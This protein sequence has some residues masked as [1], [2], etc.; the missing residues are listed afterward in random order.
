MAQIITCLL[1]DISF[2][3]STNLHKTCNN[4]MQKINFSREAFRGAKRKKSSTQFLN[5]WIELQ[6]ICDF[7]SYN[8]KKE[9]DM[10]LNWI[11]HKSTRRQF[12]CVREKKN[13]LCFKFI[14]WAI[15]KI[16]FE[17]FLECERDSLENFCFRKYFTVSF[18]D[19]DFAFEFT[20]WRL[21][22]YET[23]FRAWGGED[24]RLPWSDFNRHRDGV[25]SMQ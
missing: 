6:E 21:K 14:C 1:C 10:K 8:F 22:I 13:R 20:A 11:V 4:A 15:N 16:H 19:C 24:G 12:S 23:R 17:L 2:V 18:A 7:P 3:G 25:F 5:Y 9:R